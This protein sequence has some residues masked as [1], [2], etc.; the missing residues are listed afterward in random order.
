MAGLTLFVPE[1]ARL[2]LCQGLANNP[3]QMLV[4]GTMNRSWF[5]ALPHELTSAV[6]SL[7]ANFIGGKG[8]GENSPSKVR[9]LNS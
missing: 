8:R 5:L 4:I 3:N 7:S 1:P 9:A 2:T 6:D